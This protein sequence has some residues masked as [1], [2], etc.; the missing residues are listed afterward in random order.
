MLGA[1]HSEEGR[2]VDVDKTFLIASSV[3][4]DAI[5]VPGG[6]SAPTLAR[7][8]AAVQW[9]REAFAHAKP[10]GASNEGAAVLEAAGLPG[11]DFK[12]RSARSRPL[13]SR[14]VVLGTGADLGDFAEAFAEAIREHRH[15]DRSL[16]EVAV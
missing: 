16:D 6:A 15:F 4:Y 1:L 14:G 10:I 2:P 13:A 3:L 8:G 5:Y 9:V 11:L 7:T 12:E